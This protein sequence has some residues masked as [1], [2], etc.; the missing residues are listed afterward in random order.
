MLSSNSACKHLDAD[1]ENS[2]MQPDTV[3][4]VITEMHIN[5]NK[6]THF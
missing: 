2:E 3:I 4:K 5:R 1:T 6:T